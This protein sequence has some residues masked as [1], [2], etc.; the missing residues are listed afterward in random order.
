MRDTAK[1]VNFGIIYGMS[2]YGLS[3]D[4]K[5]SPAQAR[6]FIEAY[7]KRYPGVKS[8]IDRQIKEA[9]RNNF[10]I[11]LLKRRRYIPQIKSPNENMRQFARRV[12]INAPVQGSASD[13]IK[14]AMVNIY[15]SLNKQGLSTRMIIQVHDE[16][17]FSV[18]R[19]ELEI[20]RILIKDKMENVIKLKAPIKV[21]IKVG[22]NWLEMR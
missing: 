13:L 19:D 16:L 5:I 9:E 14:A 3:R 6:E 21:S 15:R 11:T 22:K 12:A 18:P 20:A 4:L 10:V 17:V 1:T 2:S 7:F 8:Y